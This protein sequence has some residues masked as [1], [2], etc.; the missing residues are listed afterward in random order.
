[1]SFIDD[2]KDKAADAAEFVKDKA[3]DAGE[4]IGDKAEGVGEWVKD[5]VEDVKD[6]FDGDDDKPAATPAS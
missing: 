4:W 2:A 5:T 6:R 1:M 3:E